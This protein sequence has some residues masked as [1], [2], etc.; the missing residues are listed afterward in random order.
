MNQSDLA[1]IRERLETLK[2]TGELHPQSE[3]VTPPWDSPRSP[4]LPVTPR[5]EPSPHQPQLLD[6]VQALQ[7]RSQPVTAATNQATVMASGTTLPAEITLHW[8]RLQ[9][10]ATQINTLAQQQAIAIQNFKRSADRLAWSLRKHPGNSTLAIDQFCELHDAVVSQ[11]AQ[12]DDGKLVLAM[13]TVDLYEDE[14]QASRTAQD[15]RA[16]SQSHVDQALNATTNLGTVLRHPL[17]V[18]QSCWHTV[19]RTL[20][21]RSRLT[22]LDI[23]IWIGGGLI[24]RLALELSL[25]ALPSLWPW[26]VGATIG[27]VALGLYRLLFSPHPDIAFVTRLFLALLGLALGGQL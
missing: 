7:R 27:A 23:V 13:A 15:I 22:T 21:T 4:E 18:V 12:T 25:A 19:T 11:V 16:R 1:P 17:A 2:R 6:T 24:G 5:T 10:E 3:A 9:Q 8:Q 26:L 14:R 20:E